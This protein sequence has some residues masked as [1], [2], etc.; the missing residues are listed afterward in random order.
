MER[1]HELYLDKLESTA[2]KL[3]ALVAKVINQNDVVKIPEAQESMDKEW[4][5][6]LYK[7]CW[8]ESQ[9]REFE[10]AQKEVKKKKDK[11]PISEGSSKS[12]ASRVPSYLNVHPRRMYK[13]RSVFQRNQVSG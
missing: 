1:L 11:R 12:A 5:K 13:G 7:V 3:Y 6:L 8:V 4:Q 9:V 2:E 10:D